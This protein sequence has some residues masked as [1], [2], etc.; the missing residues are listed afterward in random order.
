MSGSATDNLP[1]KPRVHI[2]YE[3]EENG[4]QVRKELPFVV[5]VI[6]DF[7]GDPTQ[8]LK[9]LSQREFV[10]IDF[11]SFDEVFSKMN[12][13]LKYRV[14]NTIAG[15]GSEISVD[16]KFN[17]IKDLEP[18]QVARQVE[19]IRRLLEDREKLVELVS[20]VESSEK[21]EEALRKIFSDNDSVKRLMDE[22]KLNQKGS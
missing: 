11:E 21:L 8:E 2:V 9:P 1:N 7:S 15:D 19:P 14:E 17:S 18:G 5:G 12:P 13:G 6:G 22:L 16:L 10:N 20:K 3:V 4:A